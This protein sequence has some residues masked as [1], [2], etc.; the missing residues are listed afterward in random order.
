MFGLRD[1]RA[2][3]IKRGGGA[4]RDRNSEKNLYLENCIP[5]RTQPK[6]PARPGTVKI[7]ILSFIQRSLQ[8]S[9]SCHLAVF[10]CAVEFFLYSCLKK[11]YRS[12]KQGNY[13]ATVAAIVPSNHP[14]L[15]LLF[16]IYIVQV[17][18]TCLIAEAKQTKQKSCMRMCNCEGELMLCHVMSCPSFA[19][20]FVCFMLASCFPLLCL[21]QCSKI[22]DA[23]NVNLQTSPCHSAFYLCE[24]SL[25]RL[26]A[27]FH[28]AHPKHFSFQHSCCLR[29]TSKAPLNILFSKC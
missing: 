22:K 24:R 14:L 6:D 20:C 4:P 27:P 17:D 7:E 1:A 25:K 8:F 13:K 12:L 21:L 3:L 29:S 5:E 28:M 10:R 26:G 2:I 23:K 9:V 19:S 18:L 15:L 11:F 16:F